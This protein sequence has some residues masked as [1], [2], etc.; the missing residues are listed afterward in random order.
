MRILH[1]A[2]WHL[3]DRLQHI[4]RSSELQRAVE[5]IAGYAVEEHVDVV[6]VAGDLFS[7]LARADSVQRSVQHLAEV[8]RSFLLQGGTI[9]ALTGNHDNECFCE[10][11]GRAFQLAAPTR[12]RPDGVLPP[13]RLYLSMNPTCFRLVDGQG[14][15]VQF[16]CLPYPRPRHYLDRDCQN[17]ATLREKHRALRAAVV[18]RLK[19]LQ[20]RLDPKLPSVLAAHLYVVGSLPRKQFH[21]RE[22]QDVVVG[23]SA[24]TSGWAYTALGHL[25][26]PQMILG[27]PQVRYSGS[28]ERL[29][30]G[31]Q[32]DQK[33]AVL[34][35][36]GASGLASAPI[37]MPLPATTFYDVRISNP[38]EELPQLATHYPDAKN[39]LVRC[40]IDYRSGED[41]LYEILEEV[42][43]IF[44]RCYERSWK[45]VGTSSP[46]DRMAREERNASAPTSGPRHVAQDD[47]ESGGA[48]V[49]QIVI[50]YLR[51]QLA[52]DA[53]RDELLAL[54]ERLL[55]E[56][57]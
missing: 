38:R 49:E 47:G 34:V 53:D 18:E 31:E 1:T 3:G 54:A 56:T 57:L 44:P 36:I 43:R 45:A 14:Q 24:F 25:H 9:V 27:L 42:A 23:H 11:L 32:D 46:R 19:R 17:Y 33:G 16:V 26:K 55:E 6:L 8:F 51:S 2:D 5:R 48:S 10:I 50:R 12:G 20:G 22:L 7:D 37:V 30:I 39:A 52:D 41:N 13:G 15:A 28:I 29:D 4:D 35:E 40:H 21:L